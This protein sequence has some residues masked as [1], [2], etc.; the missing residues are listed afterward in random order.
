M[1]GYFE[2]GIPFIDILT[3]LAG[4]QWEVDTSDTFLVMCGSDTGTGTDKD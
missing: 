4:I 2:T 3:F 1:M